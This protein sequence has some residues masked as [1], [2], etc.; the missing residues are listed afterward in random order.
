[1]ADRM[2]LIGWGN[3][4]RGLEERAL[5]VFN[6]AMGLLGRM[7]QEGRIES[8]DVALLAP[9]SDLD[10]YIRITG[11]A[12]QIAG[13]RAD[14][15]FQR[16]TVDAQLCVDGIRHI[17]GYTNEGVA[18]QMAMYQEAIAQIPQRA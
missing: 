17:D 2:L 5:E 7:Q 4:V 13:V 1:M 11:T 9:N 3:P 18:T 8:F 16:N 6:D 10:G 15:E 14:E 12:E